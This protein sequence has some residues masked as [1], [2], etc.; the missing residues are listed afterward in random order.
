M[1]HH[2]TTVDTHEFL[3]VTQQALAAGDLAALA[4]CVQVRYRTRDL[5]QLLGDESPK[6]RQT[7][8]VTL[9]LVGKQD[10]VR[11]LARTLRDPVPAVADAA[12]H[13][14]WGIWFRS[15]NALASKPFE[16]GL[17][18]MTAEAF[19]CAGRCF[20][21]A[22]GYDPAFAE[23]YHQGAIAAF[24]L[25]DWPGVCSLSRKALE[26]EPL[27]FGALALLGH[28]HTQAGDYAQALGAY[29]RA[30]GINPRM[31]AIQIM[32][33]KLQQVPEQGGNGA[34]GVY[35]AIKY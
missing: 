32:I 21:E 8:A 33:E 1:R 23:A 10:I 14:M 16:D 2:S 24:L 7:A 30:V 19:E 25:G 35:A 31:Q 6:V 22:A 28:C 27:H 15:G 5:C 4:H 9:G 13:A 11:C 29:R 3:A 17:S 20:A 26:G 12:E 34:S 18:L